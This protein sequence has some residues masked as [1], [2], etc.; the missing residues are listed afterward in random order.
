MCADCPHKSAKCH[1]ITL[2]IQ[3]W[4]NPSASAMEEIGHL[5]MLTGVLSKSHRNKA[6]ILIL[7]N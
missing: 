7:M 4:I 2:Q 3:Q 6:H 1:L 5:E